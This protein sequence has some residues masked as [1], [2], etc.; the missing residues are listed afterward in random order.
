MMLD[1]FVYRQ[2]TVVSGSCSKEIFITLYSLFVVNNVEIDKAIFLDHLQKDV[3]LIDQYNDGLQVR[4]L[5]FC[6]I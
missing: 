6:A 3:M 5:L 1:I 4:R 2:S